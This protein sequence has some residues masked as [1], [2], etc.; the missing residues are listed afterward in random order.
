MVGADLTVA[1]MLDAFW[2]WGGGDLRK[3]QREKAGDR[4][5]S[6]LGD[7]ATVQRIIG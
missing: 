1:L 5:D 3:V 6:G 7:C 4:P 2:D